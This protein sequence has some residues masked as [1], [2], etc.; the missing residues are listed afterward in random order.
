MSTTEKKRNSVLS[1]SLLQSI[2][3]VFSQSIPTTSSPSDQLAKLSVTTPTTSS[4][5]EL[6]SDVPQLAAT[7]FVD[8]S[9][10]IYSN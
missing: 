4:S 10:S 7:E 5:I 3:Q 6:I 2:T 1:A 8:I 9:R